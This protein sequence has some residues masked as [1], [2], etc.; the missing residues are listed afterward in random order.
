MPEKA[1]S[2][3]IQTASR[4]RDLQF[5]QSIIANLFEF[6]FFTRYENCKNGLFLSL[7]KWMALKKQLRKYEN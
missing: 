4:S 7:A 6:L 2:Q 5:R 3:E 1:K